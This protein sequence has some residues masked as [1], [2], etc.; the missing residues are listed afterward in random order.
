[1]R[2]GE[3]KKRFLIL[4]CAFLA[5]S[6]AH[7]R[8]QETLFSPCLRWEPSQVHSY[9]ENKKKRA[10][11]PQARVLP[12][13][14]YV[15]NKKKRAILPQELA[16]P[17]ASLQGKQEKN[18][19]FPASRSQTKGVST[20][21]T[22]KKELLPRKQDPNQGRF[23]RENKKKRASSPQA[24]SLPRALLRGK[25]ENKRI[26]RACG[27]LFKGYAMRNRG[28]A[29]LLVRFFRTWYGLPATG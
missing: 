23:Y 15:E 13:A 6:L 27:K 8:R 12:R 2:I 28:C 3:G 20:G 4:A 18:R 11:S 7:K 1:M 16:L 22:R 24:R 17:R 5:F 21:K 26:S 14:S 25:Q 9:G 29:N 10:F 19:F